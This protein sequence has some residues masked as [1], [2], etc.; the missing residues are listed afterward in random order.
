[1]A[2]YC[3]MVSRRARE[4]GAIRDGITAADLM[5]LL[6]GCAP[7]DRRALSLELAL[8]GDLAQFGSRPALARAAIRTPAQASAKPYAAAQTTSTGIRTTAGSDS[9]STTATISGISAIAVPSRAPR[10]P[11]PA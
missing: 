3:R 6:G 11:P 1:M 7:R 4:A 2:K 8:H 9:V 5:A 10:A